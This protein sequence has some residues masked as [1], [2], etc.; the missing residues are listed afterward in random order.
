MA[1]RRN[2]MLGSALAFAA[3]ALLV[4]VSRPRSTTPASART[5]AATETNRLLSP[6]LQLPRPQAAASAPAAAPPDEPGKTNLITR[7]IHGE[8]P[9]ALS[10][11]QVEPYLA[12][13]HRNAA[14]LLAAFRTTHDPAFLQEALQKYPNDPRVNFA[15][16]FKPGATPEERRQMIDNFKQS[17][18]N[19]PLANYLSARDYFKSGQAE[20][21]LQEIS[22]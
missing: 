19:N 22:A 18:P 20:S 16:I 3:L 1:I 8:Q 21:A 11:E 4:Y 10:A 12:A 15:A 9:P 7:I 2:I 5:A 13:N 17:D 6:R 14:S